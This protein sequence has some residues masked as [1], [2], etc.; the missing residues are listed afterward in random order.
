MVNREYLAMLENKS[1]IR[2]LSEY[3]NARGKEI[4]YEK[5]VMH[6]MLSVVGF[7]EKLGFKQEGD[8]FEEKGVRLVRMVKEL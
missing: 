6:A 8:I 7:Y 3:A 2:E 1:V 5:M 4:G